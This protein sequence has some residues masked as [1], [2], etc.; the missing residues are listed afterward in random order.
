MA[1]PLL[2]VV[3]DES[4]ILLALEQALTE[5]GFEVLGA[6]SGDQAL[7]L[8][9]SN[10]E[11]ING[12]ITDIGIRPGPDGW[13]LGQR[14]R[15]QMSQLPVVYTSGDAAS[16]WPSR[17]VPNSIMLSKP[18]ALAQVITAISQL[19]NAVQ[20]QQAMESPKETGT[21]RAI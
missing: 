14:L 18:Y 3:E 7:V 21:A 16:E 4:L 17:G 11:R 20:E 19:I 5:A 2:L 10:A 15:E 12:L 8:I 9:A 1:G 6:N 13:D